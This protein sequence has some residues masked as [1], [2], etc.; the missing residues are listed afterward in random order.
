MNKSPEE[1]PGFLYIHCMKKVSFSEWL[2]V[3]ES[4][5]RTR[6]RSA[7]ARKLLPPQ[8]DWNSGS[9]PTPWEGEQSEKHFKASHRKGKK[10]KKKLK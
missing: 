10:S 8:A 6:K 4:T 9:T 3:R 1:I 2:M 7:Q 5:A